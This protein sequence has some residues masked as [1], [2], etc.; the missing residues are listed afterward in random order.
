MIFFGLNY[1]ALI[2]LIFCAVDLSSRLFLFNVLQRWK[3]QPAY[4]VG[5][6]AASRVEDIMHEILTEGPVVAVMDVYKDFFYYGDGVYQVN[7]TK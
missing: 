2:F 5:E 1:V 3:V 4:R 6:D 7:L